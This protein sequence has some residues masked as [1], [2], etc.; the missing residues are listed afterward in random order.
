MSKRSEA[1]S[2]QI[3]KEEEEDETEIDDG[4]YTAMMYDESENI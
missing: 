2:F 3:V 4:K 1:A